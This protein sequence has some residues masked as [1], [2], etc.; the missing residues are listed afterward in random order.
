[1]SKAPTLDVFTR[2]RPAAPERGAPSTVL[3]SAP[4]SGLLVRQRMIPDEAFANGMLGA[5]IA[6]D[7]ITASLC[8]PCDGEV[9][10]IAKTNH[11]ATVRAE[12]GAELLLHIGIETVKLAGEGFSPRAAVGARVRAGAPLIDFDMDL[13]ARNAKSLVTPIIIINGGEYAMTRSADGDEI[14]AG[15]FLMEVARRESVEAESDPHGAEACG[16]ATIRLPHGLHARP[17]A[18]I[19]A[20]AREFSAVVEIIAKSGTADARSISS[21]MALGVAYRDQVTIR[22]RGC[23]ASAA[24]D[25]IQAILQAG[26]VD[27]GIAKPVSQSV[28]HAITS[29]SFVIKGITASPGIAIGVA[30]PMEATDARIEEFGE[31]AAKERIRLDKALDDVRLRLAEE[32]AGAQPPHRDILTA[33]V[34]LLA[35]PELLTGAQ[36]HI[37]AGKS[38]AYAWRSVMRDQAARLRALDDSRIA[39]RAAD[40][41]DL[42]RQT[43]AALR[44]EAGKREETPEGAV[45]VGD[46]SLP[47][48]LLS[49]DPS[50]VAGIVTARGGA[51]SHA[52]ILAASLGIPAIVAAGPEVM[53]VA[54]GTTI[55]VDADAAMAHVS[56]AADLIAATRTRIQRKRDR[57]TRALAAAAEDC[58]TVDGVRVEVF[59]N[60]ASISEAEFA[61]ENFAEGCGL[62]RTEFL[63]LDRQSP[64]SED[65]QTA[66]YQAIADLLGD[67]ALVI[68]TLDVGADKSV[69]YLT[70]DDEANPALGLRG[71]RMGLANPD[72][73]EAQLRAILR[74]RPHGR[75][76]ILLPMITALGELRAVRLMLVRI[77]GENARLGVMIETPA[78]ALIAD[79]LAAEADFLSIGTNDLAQYAFA[80]DRGNASVASNIDALDPAVMRLIQMTAEAGARRR[81]PVS[82]CGG[83]ASDFEAAPL[84]IGLGVTALSGAA[85]RIPEMK[86]FVRTLR[87]DHC[88]K[89]ARK[90]L[91][92]EDAG[93][94]RAHARDLWRQIAEWTE[95]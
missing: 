72:L 81:K 65:E 18:E 88:V 17:A 95:V 7:P 24:R 20:R 38:A 61:M 44:G 52:S 62:L 32:I 64:P 55:I 76:R 11:A 4:L 13:A 54:A 56:P 70:V 90:A 35:D 84:L 6:I 67:R 71:I 33:H 48:D 50:R 78:A 3:I 37:S 10:A 57:R 86:A 93:A 83:L 45:L 80:M 73:L 26:S 69:P 47:S 91:D 1:M 19:A 31:D 27:D 2:L 36:A 87:K 25:A 30:H 74:V 42:E 53:S 60:L 40:F 75:C 82:V 79:R 58:V 14:F 41:I 23:N 94:V 9:I 28:T 12:N 92:F 85:A 51:T 8:A 66:Q 29:G 39:E 68:R 59:A 21:L 5:G 63:F 15:E 46:E 34:E 22:A 49:L 43:L 77:G 16:A 89:A